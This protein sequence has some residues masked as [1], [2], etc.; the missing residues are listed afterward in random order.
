MVVGGSAFLSID[1]TRPMLL[2]L[3][4]ALFGLLLLF[5]LLLGASAHALPLGCGL[6]AALAAAG[7]GWSAPA[8]LAAGIG[9]VLLMEAALA[10]AGARWRLRSC[11]WPVATLLV[12]PAAIAGYSVGAL[13]AAWL[14]FGDPLLAAATALIAAASAGRSLGVHNG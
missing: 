13:A 12:V 14:G 8:V 3:P 6:A 4:V 11:R 9:V 7:T 1:W 5:R 10:F 2:F